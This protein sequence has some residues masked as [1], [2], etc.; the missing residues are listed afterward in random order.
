MALTPDEELELLQLE[1]EEYQASL[2]KK[3]SSLDQKLQ[4][5]NAQDLALQQSEGRKIAEA[6]LTGA[7]QG[8]T[9]G[10]SDELG[11]GADVAKDAL[12]GNAS[13][14]NLYNKYREYQKSREAANKAIKEE[15][16]NAYMAGEIGGGLG[17]AILT[18]GLTAAKVAATGGK[19]LGSGAKTLL[20]GETGS[21]LANIAGKGLNLG[22]QAAPAGAAYGIGAS[23]SNIEKPLE[24]ASDAV[25]GA[26]MGLIGGSALGAAGQTGK[27]A[28]K[29][30][31][32]L[33]KDSD[34]LRQL[35]SSYEYGKKGLNLGSS[36]TQDKI[37]LIPGQ[38]AEDL[39]NKIFET[40]EMIGKK[41]GKALEDAQQ[42]G[43]RINVE[44]QLKASVDDLFNTLFVESPS[45]GKIF[46]PKSAKIINT[47]AKQKVGDLNP[48]EARALKDELYGLRD[49]LAGF[50]SDQANLAKGKAS[51]LASALDQSLKANI[52]EYK[53]AASQFEEFRRLVPESI[54]TKG[55]PSD[56]N[57][58]Y[59]GSLKNPELK[60][61]ESSKEMLKK[62]KLPGEAAVDERASFEVLR[63]NLE[64]LQQSNPEATKKLGG[65]A[66]D[67]T[68]KLKKQA[69]ELAM[70]R[71][72][73]GFD[74]QEGPRG[75][76]TGAISGLVT[77]GRGLSVSAAN[78]AGLV[79]RS[80]GKSTPATAMQ[81][82][83]SADDGALMNVAS[84]LKESPATEYIGNSLEVALQNKNDTAK[85]AVLFKLMQIPEYREMLSGDKENE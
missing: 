11:A 22:L 21:A 56:F 30:V 64:K 48:I 80:A 25:S 81:R 24:L 17:G 75:V 53:I 15:S 77:T 51:E 14:D 57:K 12:T 54:L 79:S 2:A 76:L 84:K 68:E 72:A 28:F 59:V 61:F 60:L 71:Q 63:R 18:P 38:R 85:K 13:L 35:G 43:V 37:S 44:P 23:E 70:I 46:D 10:F 42:N 29:G 27:E 7:T 39:V 67:I 16:P 78:K 32:E 65:S 19:L 26:T 1:E 66:K 41:V 4:D 33:A 58:T 49:K 9:F 50:N 45:L 74:P 69:D 55:V 3:P 5:A 40:D 47:I 36:K 20:A 34:F 82:V 73:Q 52:P 62:A 31:K 8:A 83:F 6:A